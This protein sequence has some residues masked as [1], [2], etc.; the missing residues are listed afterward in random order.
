MADNDDKLKI[1]TDGDL[2]K[3]PGSGGYE[4]ASDLEINKLNST[5]I[6]AKKDGNKID[7]ELDL[8]T[9]SLEENMAE[10]A[11]TALAVGNEAKEIENNSPNLSENEIYPESPTPEEKLEEINPEQNINETE[12]KPP[13]HP[14]KEST[15]K[16][17]QASGQE[18]APQENNISDTSRQ[19]PNNSPI[20]QPPQSATPLDQTQPEITTPPDSQPTERGQTTP[21]VIQNQPSSNLPPTISNEQI[22]EI[23][24]HSNQAS[25]PPKV[26]T[27]KQKEIGT[28]LGMDQTKNKIG[29]GERIKNAPQNMAAGLKNIKNAPKNILNNIK[30]NLSSD[31][32]LKQKLQKRL[33]KVQTELASL[34]TRLNGLKVSNSMRIIKFFFPG[35]YAKIFNF[36][37]FSTRLK[38]VAKLRALQISVNTGEAILRSLKFA[39]IVAIVID[40]HRTFITWLVEWS[41]TI[42]VPILM[43][44]TYPLLILLIIIQK[45]F[46]KLG[47][48]LA[49][50]IEDIIK[51]INEIMKDLKK[52]LETTKKEVG[53]IRE[54]MQINK[55]MAS[56]KQDRIEY[57][58]RAEA[59]DQNEES[60]NQA[61]K[62]ANDNTKSDNNDSSSFPSA[63][64]DN[65]ESDNLQQAA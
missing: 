35:L 58:N 61:Q 21:P 2:N 49:N 20:D 24:P 9:P 62:A 29:L 37:N 18:T 7:L 36:S 32:A 33:Q 14:T 4:K 63:A 46:T 8:E 15:P 25:N 53:L 26:P 45:D 39:R 43:I 1:E 12:A 30:N 13:I 51:K 52:A 50:A 59:N 56:S 19:E 38:G 5:G 27:E 34:G 57:L 22:N 55:Q 28:D 54:A 60:K 6:K 11:A 42:I 65:T 17:N 3:R 47:S 64:N 10:V 40:A 44:I 16:N 31:R 41:E 23:G 48:S